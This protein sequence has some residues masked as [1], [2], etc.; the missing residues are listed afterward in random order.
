MPKPRVYIH[1]LYYCTY[2]LYMDAGN[3]A[4]LTSFADVVSHADRQ[5]AVPPEE[6]AEGLRG[7]RAILSFN[8][9]GAEDVTTEL[10]KQA[11]TVEF[12]VISHWWHGSSDAAAEAWRQAGVLVYD[13]SDGCNEAVAEWTVGAA[14]AGLRRFDHYDRAMKRGEPWPERIGVAGQLTG[15][16]LGLV[17]LGRVGRLVARFLRPF[18]VRLL[19]YDPFIRPEVAAELGVELVDLDTLLRTSAAVSLHLPVTPETRGIIGRRELALMRDGA[20]LINS[21]RAAL[22]DNEALREELASGRLRAYLDVF[23]P[24][25]PPP[26]DILRRLDN[27]VLT[28][29]LAGHTGPMYLDCGR[30]AIEKLRELLVP[31]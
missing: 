23:E 12:A 17:G 30:R 8:G 19:A 6:V 22:L 31:H 7:A 27:V 28:P 26:D 9:S 4:L 1:R 14:I 13:V 29:H 16:T 5:R 25:P 2:D 24:E 10:L 15:S 18:R 3:E 20:L 21:A 11:G